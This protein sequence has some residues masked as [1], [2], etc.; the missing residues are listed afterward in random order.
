MFS[1]ADYREIVRLIQASGK[2]A[3]F[4]QVK[5]EPH[6]PF[7]LMR[8]DVEFSVERALRMAVL[9]AEENFFS[10]YFFQLTNNAYNL[11]SQQNRT[12][13]RE[14]YAM[15]HTVG[16]HFRL[17]GTRDLNRI[18]SRIQ[19]E[20]DIMEES[21]EF[22]VTSFSFHRP[23]AEVLRANIQL[24][25]MINTYED[26]FFS[27][28][29]DMESAPPAIKYLSDARHQWNYGLQPDDKTIMGNERIQILTHPYSWTAQGYD[30]RDNLRTLLEEK[31][32]ELAATI[33]SECKHFAEARHVL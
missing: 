26:C 5:Q 32:R 16:L 2:Q 10:A 29:E 21:L 18:A 28:T 33:D 22:D 7:V 19:L 1:Y 17:N 11:L 25:G 9:E 23:T 24:Y 6:R 27:F 15:G 4:H 3:D 20:I 31:N 13:V 8:H 14:I 12:M 30:N